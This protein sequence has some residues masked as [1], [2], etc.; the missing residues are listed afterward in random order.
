M[1]NLAALAAE[2]AEMV[3]VRLP[4][5]VVLLF[6]AQAAA[7]AEAELQPVELSRPGHPGAGAVSM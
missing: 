5:S 7:V 2:S 1:Q 6:T 3:S 4:A